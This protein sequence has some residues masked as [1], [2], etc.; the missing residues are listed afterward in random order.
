MFLLAAGLCAVFT[1]IGLYALW[2]AIRL[3]V[4]GARVTGVITEVERDSGEFPVVTFRPEGRSEQ[5]TVRSDV[6][7]SRAWRV[8]E[9]VEVL[10]ARHDPSVARIASTG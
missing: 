9:S 2:R 6:S 8:G 4:L 1:S 7:T 3:V 5:V 10:H